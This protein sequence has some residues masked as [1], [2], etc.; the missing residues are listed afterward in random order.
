L[1]FQQRT[2]TS[3]YLSIPT[4]GFTAVLS[5]FR[6]TPPTKP[7]DCK[8]R[9]NS[10]G[11]HFRDPRAD[12]VGGEPRFSGVSFRLVPGNVIETSFVSYSYLQTFRFSASSIHGQQKT[13]LTHR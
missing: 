5:V 10:S 7:L 1:P 2:N 9:L 8:I 3:C 13:L 4:R 12:P 6:G 11:A